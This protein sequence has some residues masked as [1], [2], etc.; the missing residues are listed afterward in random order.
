MDS[1]KLNYSLAGWCGIELGTFSHCIA[2][3]NIDYDYDSEQRR[4]EEN[5]THDEMTRLDS[6]SFNNSTTFTL[7]FPSACG[8]TQQGRHGATGKLDGRLDWSIASS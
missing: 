1:S 8:V 2:L 7:P 5:L 6:A 3:R 4:D